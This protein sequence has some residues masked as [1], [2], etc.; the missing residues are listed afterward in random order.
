MWKTFGTDIRTLPGPMCNIQSWVVAVS[1]QFAAWIIICITLDRFA[2]IFFP[3]FAKRRFTKSRTCVVLSIVFMGLAL[4]NS[5]F[6]WSIRRNEEGVCDIN[7]DIHWLAEIFKTVWPWVDLSLYSIIPFIVITICNF[8]MITKLRLSRRQTHYLTQRQQLSRARVNS[9]TTTLLVI[10]CMY[11]VTT[12]PI[13]AFMLVHIVNINKLSSSQWMWFA[14]VNLLS[15][16]NS[17]SNFL[18]YLVSSSY[19]RTEL[20][21]MFTCGRRSSS[22]RPL[23]ESGS[24]GGRFRFRTPGDASVSQGAEDLISKERTSDCL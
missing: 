18:L 21:E 24:D 22:P 17:A 4:I 16:L 1:S 9:M 23:A 5:H 13:S 3:H 2:A 19:F 8:A 15:Y 11:L 14:L 7:T 20:V 12:L 6:F 10:S